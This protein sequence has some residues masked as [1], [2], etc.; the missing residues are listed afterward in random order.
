MSNI[1]PKFFFHLMKRHSQSLIQSMENPNHRH[2]FFQNRLKCH[3]Y[4]IIRNVQLG[5]KQMDFELFLRNFITPYPRRCLSWSV[6]S[7][8]IWEQHHNK[9]VV[10]VVNNWI[11]NTEIIFYLWGRKKDEL[12]ESINREKY[13]QPI[14]MFF[15][16]KIFLYFCI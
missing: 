6:S 3:A 14:S 2:L 8:G 11:V 7:I 16:A 1:F 9:P 5:I 12:Q 4:S 13:T 10:L 15:S